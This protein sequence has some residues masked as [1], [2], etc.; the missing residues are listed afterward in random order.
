MTLFVVLAGL[1][2]TMARWVVIVE[3]APSLEYVAKRFLRLIPL[4]TPGAIVELLAFWS[5]GTL[6]LYIFARNQK[7]WHGTVLLLA[8]YIGYLAWTLV[9]AGM[10]MSMRVRL[11]FELAMYLFTNTGMI[12]SEVGTTAARAPWELIL[13]GVGFAGAGIFAA[14]SADRTTL[15]FHLPEA[16]GRFAT[17]LFGFALVSI[18][19][20]LYARPEIHIE[21]EGTG[22]RSAEQAALPPIDLLTPRRTHF[23]P[24]F[25]ERYGFHL[26]KGTNV[27]FFV[28]ESARSE[29]VDLGRT[30]HFRPGRGV[31][32]AQ[33]FYVPVPH[34][35][36][37]H[38]SLFTGNHSARHAK[39]DYGNIHAQAALPGIL[40]AAG[41]DCRYI[42]G[43][44]TEFDREDEMLRDLGLPVTERRD[45]KGPYSEFEWGLDDRALK[46]QVAS[47]LKKKKGPVFYTIVFTN[48][49][50]PYFNPDPARFNR[51]DNSG[52]L[53]RHRNA[54]D[55]ALKL[56]DEIVDEFAAR[57]LDR[58]TLFVLLSDHGES[59]GERG[60]WVHDF[61][62]FDEEVK[63]PMVMRHRLFARVDDKK[64]FATGT[65]L[66]IGPTVVDLLGLSFPEPVDGK[67]LFDPHYELS[68]LLRAWGSDDHRGFL[69][70]D[71]RWV[72]NR[73]TG[74]MVRS[75]TGRP[76]ETAV[77]APADFIRALYAFELGNPVRKTETPVSNQA[78][79]TGL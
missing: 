12:G 25:R 26:P 39:W 7:R 3:D 59:F 37:S 53:G 8:A 11:T 57:G 47:L 34:S 27:V 75:R 4:E 46:D 22:D 50:L 33:N 35:S 60:F 76:G 10:E 18:P 64:G 79:V 68:L 40:A 70:K 14:R 61:S 24:H 30:K 2:R 20:S 13:I 32:A 69:W 28:L 52:R 49:H 6:T 71:S 15:E 54:L 63:V 72:Y 19:V 77:T 65:I 1:A 62:L 58:N 21:T 73:L 29:Y 9:G 78:K 23:R 51:F 31:M 45:M 17:V 41:Y 67:S 42:Y 16:P 44:D 38:Y 43:G 36:N 56:S 48:S 66:D 5:V 74:E 55:Y